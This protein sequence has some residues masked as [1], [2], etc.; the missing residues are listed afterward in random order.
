MLHNSWSEQSPLMEDNSALSNCLDSLIRIIVH[1]PIRIIVHNQPQSEILLPK[2]TLNYKSSHIRS[3]WCVSFII[4]K[5]IASVFHPPS[6]STWLGVSV[7][8][9]FFIVCQ[10]WII[11]HGVFLTSLCSC[12]CFPNSFLIWS[13]SWDCKL[14]FFGPTSRSYQLKL[15]Y[16]P[17]S[18]RKSPWCFPFCIFLNYSAFLFWVFL[19]SLFLLWYQDVQN[20]SNSKL[21]LDSSNNVNSI[22]MYSANFE[23]HS[24]DTLASHHVH[25][26]IN[27]LYFLYY[28]TLYRCLWIWK[29]CL[30]Y[31]SSHYCNI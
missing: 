20:N 9:L 12:V 14:D 3:I 5:S 25:A 29:Y 31:S 1:N 2:L 13:S 18:W 30:K 4:G 23:C 15:A 10:L 24:E 6:T 28:S 26:Y 22:S 19:L 7:P 11:F 17:P 16:T 8:L 27:V 21:Y